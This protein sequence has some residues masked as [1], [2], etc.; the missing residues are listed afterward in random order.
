VKFLSNVKDSIASYYDKKK[1]QRE[2]DDK[3]EREARA[4][5]R[6]IY[7]QEYKKAALQ[8]AMLRAKKDAESKTGLAKL[9]AINQKY[10]SPTKSRGGFLNKLSE[11]TKENRL[12]NEQNIKRTEELRKAAYEMR[13]NR[14]TINKPINRNPNKTLFRY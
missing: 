9:R 6:K 4:T 10:S 12:R 14:P 8:A 2:Y 1:E 3:L 5:E 7:E 11:Y 13:V